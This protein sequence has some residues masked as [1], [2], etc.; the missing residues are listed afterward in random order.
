[1]Q[2]AN[3]KALQSL[4]AFL[5]DMKKPV[6]YDSPMSPSGST[7]AAYNVSFYLLPSAEELEREKEAATLPRSS[8]AEKEKA[9][10]ITPLRRVSFVLQTSASYSRKGKVTPPHA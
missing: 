8:L 9:P 7:D 5:D 2:E 10:H 3:G 1:M 6:G 4:M